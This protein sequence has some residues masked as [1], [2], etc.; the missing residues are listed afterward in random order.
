M[1]TIKL[2]KAFVDKC[3]SASRH[4]KER[5]EKLQTCTCCGQEKPIDAFYTQSITGLPTGQCK[6]CINVKRSVVRHKAKHGK[7]LSKER[8]RAL[9]EPNYTL[10][11]WRDA[12][13]HFAGECPI[14][15]RKE[16]R[17]KKSKF[18]RD[19]LVPISKG[20]KTVRNNVVPCCAAC[21]RS[22]GNKEIFEWFR[23]QPTWTQERED[24]IRAWMLQEV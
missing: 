3:N 21:N 8:Q 18:D 13:I 6:V 5:K 2:P 12:V 9:E 10:D 1:T 11:D 22:R 14:C 24:K 16:G 7:F 20:G 17:S 4:A 23:Q 15:G 19:H